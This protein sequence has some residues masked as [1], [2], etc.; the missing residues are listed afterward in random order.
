[1]IRHIVVWQ[2]KSEDP[3]QKQADIAYVTEQL[4]GLNGRVPTL[5]TLRVHA[6][7]ARTDGNWDVG[8][9]ADYESHDDLDAYQVHPDHE[10][11]VANIK[12]LFAAR[13]S[14]DFEL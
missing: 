11:V 9:V 13:A 10:A 3:A 2:L 12:S 4:E 14:L 5:K 6:D 7:V 8:L 1:M